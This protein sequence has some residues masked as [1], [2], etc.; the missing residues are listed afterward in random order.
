MSHHISDGGHLFLLISTLTPTECLPFL[1]MHVVSWLSE[2]DFSL[3][4]Q[5]N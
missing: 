3:G 2:L 4:A 1:P 5:T